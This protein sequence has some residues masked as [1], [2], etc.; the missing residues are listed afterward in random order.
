MMN[1]V[2]NTVSSFFF[3]FLIHEP[4]LLPRQIKYEITRAHNSAFGKMH[5]ALSF[6]VEMRI[7]KF[8]ISFF[9]GKRD[10]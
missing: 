10:E 8:A 5:S 9:L 1:V 7:E 2:Y 3:F 4:T 6:F